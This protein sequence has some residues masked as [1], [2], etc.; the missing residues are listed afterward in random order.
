MPIKFRCKFCHQRM[1][2]AHRKAGTEVE[3]PSCKGKVMVPL[4]NEEADAAPAPAPE[5][6]PLVFERND[7]GDFLN[8]PP[9]PEP[10][11]AAAPQAAASPQP[12]ASPQ[13]AA[14]PAP[15]QR[16]LRLPSSFDF[17]ALPGTMGAPLDA[18]PPGIVLSPG[19]A[20][21]LTVAVILGLALAFSAGL[22]VGRAL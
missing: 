20:T 19:R 8:I 16:P 1:G 10:A 11:L 6:N 4:K 13:A 15:Q 7:F 9:Q 14:P 21:L 2:I 5:A 12:A 22:L 17:D 18:S 3:C